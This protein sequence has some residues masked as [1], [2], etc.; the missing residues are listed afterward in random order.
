[1][2]VTGLAGMLITFLG[3]LRRVQQ[4]SLIARFSRKHPERAS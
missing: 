1:M 3:A 2:I 4:A